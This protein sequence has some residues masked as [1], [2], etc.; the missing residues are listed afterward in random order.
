M[1]WYLVPETLAT[2]MCL[3]SS[4]SASLTRWAERYIRK[5]GL[6]SSPGMW[7]S[8]EHPVAMPDCS[9][10][11]CSS[12]FSPSLVSYCV[13]DIRTESDPRTLAASAGHGQRD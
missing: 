9:N 5:V 7:R 4:P 11:H 6:G 8:Q 1:S 2:D 12:T 3:G 10:S 13:G